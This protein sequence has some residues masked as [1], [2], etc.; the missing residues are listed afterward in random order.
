MVSGE[1]ALSVAA[2]DGH[3]DVVRRLL[4]VKDV[5]TNREDDL[6]R[7]LLMR[8]AI[9]GHD[10]VFEALLNCFSAASDLNRPDRAGRTVLMHAVRLDRQSILA[11]LLNRTGKTSN[12]AI[13]GESDQDCY[14][15]FK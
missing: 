13:V 15:A 9:S 4:K 3:A 1:T 6:G 12:I 8:A 5:K 11:Q 14:F 10:G 7:S 2:S